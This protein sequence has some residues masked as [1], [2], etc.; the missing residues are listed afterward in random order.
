MF[1]KGQK[2]TFNIDDKIPVDDEGSALLA[3]KSV[4]GAWWLPML[5]KAFSKLNVNYMHIDGGFQSQALRALTGMPVKRHEMTDEKPHK[6]WK[7]ILQSDKKN[8]IMTA[9]CM[10]TIHGLTSGHAYTLV[11]AVKF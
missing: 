4:N 1:M 11:S 8:H 3:S 7:N 2:Y 5:E 6:V 9:S 10:K